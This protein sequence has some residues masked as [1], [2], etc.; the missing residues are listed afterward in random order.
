KH[1]NLQSGLRRPCMNWNVEALKRVMWSTLLCSSL[2]LGLATTG[3]AQNPYWS[4]RYGRDSVKRHQKEEKRELKLHQ[5]LE[6]EE[7]RKRALREIVL[8]RSSR[9]RAIAILSAALPT[10]GRTERLYPA[11]PQDSQ[12]RCKR[13]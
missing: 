9:R 6:R 8:T 7:F 5:R 3:M 13:H 4:D 1:R 10:T 2:V 12:S 11:R